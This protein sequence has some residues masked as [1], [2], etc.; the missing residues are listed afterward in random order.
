MT[1]PRNL[2]EAYI[3]ILKELNE[4]INGIPESNSVFIE[5]VR[6]KMIDIREQF[7]NLAKLSDKDVESLNA[8]N[9]SP[10]NLIHHAAQEKGFIPVYI[11]LYNADGFNFA[12]WSSLV[13]SI[14]KQAINRP[15]YL[16][17]SDAKSALR[18]SL[19]KQNEA[20]LAIYVKENKIIET[21][22][23]KD[24]LGHQLVLLQDNSVYKENI[25]YF[26]HR[27]GLYHFQKNQ[28]ILQHPVDDL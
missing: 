25:Y 20:Y 2:K 18:A 8:P 4:A 10:K 7:K 17:E 28:L 24:R 23:A 22:T 6:K 1:K 12:K 5:A 14:E 9:L 15:V 26:I 16:S 11:L 27:S 19:N 13:A 21:Q 3:D